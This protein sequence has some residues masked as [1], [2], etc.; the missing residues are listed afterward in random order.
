MTTAPT[1]Q[2]R[3][4]FGRGSGLF[5]AALL[6]G[7]LGIVA[8]RSR[9]SGVRM[10]SLIV[11]L[12]LSAVGMSACGNS[13]SSSTK[14]PGTPKGSYI[15]KISATTSGTSPVSNSTQVTLIVQ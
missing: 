15:V 2:L 6:P 8:A 7:L 9:K 1:A 10:L 5:Y 14:N 11:V 4:P 3:P 12:G 13:T